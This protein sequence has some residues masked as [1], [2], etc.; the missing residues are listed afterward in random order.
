MAEGN[1]AQENSENKINE[2]VKNNQKYLTTTFNNFDFVY[3]LF[4]LAIL[5]ADIA[6]G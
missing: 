4:A 2:I 3:I 6:T 1:T 5:I